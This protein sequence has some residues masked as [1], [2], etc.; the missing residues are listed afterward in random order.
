MSFLE[1][2]S[3]SASRADVID[4][5]VEFVGA[6]CRPNTVIA[7]TARSPG[8]SET[9]EPDRCANH[10]LA[11]RR[12]TDA[13]LLLGSAAG[14]NV[15]GRAKRRLSVGLFCIRGMHDSSTS[16]RLVWATRHGDTCLM[17]SSGT[18]IHLP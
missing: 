1:D 12:T 8:C 17:R 18:P 11:Q 4:R 5:Y 15:C 6:R 9:D 16:V 2:V 10:G 14:C 3:A 13:A 7:P